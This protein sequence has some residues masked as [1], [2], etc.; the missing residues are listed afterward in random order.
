MIMKTKKK[1][2]AVKYMRE[3]RED[4]GKILSGMTD[5]EVVEYF[6]KIRKEKVMK[7]AKNKV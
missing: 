4:L 2:D 5:K 6:A 3:Q 1:F 7:P